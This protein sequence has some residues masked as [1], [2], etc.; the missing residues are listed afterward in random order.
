MNGK[1]GRWAVEIAS[2]PGLLAPVFVACI[3]NEGEGLVKLGHVV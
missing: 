3:T 2:Y 1:I